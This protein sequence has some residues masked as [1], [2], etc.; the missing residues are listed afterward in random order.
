MLFTRSLFLLILFFCGISQATLQCQDVFAVESQ[1]PITQTELRQMLQYSRDGSREKTVRRSYRDFF[2]RVLSQPDSFYERLSASEALD[3][4]SL[5]AQWRFLPSETWS[6]PFLKII[7]Q[8]IPLWSSRDYLAFALQRKLTPLELPES[9]LQRYRTTL[10]ENFSRLNITTQLETFSAELYHGNKWNIEE[11]SFF[12]TILTHGLQSE[13]VKLQIKPL[14]ET[15]RALHFLTDS[16]R[17]TLAPAMAELIVQLDRKLAE[18]EL[19]L[20]DGGKSGSKFVRSTTT[21]NR[22]VTLVM[23]LHQLYPRA[24]FVPE[25]LDANKIGFYDPVDLL[26]VEPKLIVEWDGGHHYFRQIATN[27]TVFEEQAHLVLRP[28]DQARDRLLR[29]AGFRIL[30]ISP[31]LAKQLDFIDIPAL[32][33]EQNP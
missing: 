20:A 9:F 11:L 21:D 32:I 17:T 8:Q 6:A 14:K 24:K 30:R 26:I 13:S 15:Y 27:G 22:Y 25:Y 7:E 33:Q 16:E 18:Y 23:D 28:T 19:S 3:Y 1:L 5:L 29:Q 4:L 12:I 10:R 31:P 2:A